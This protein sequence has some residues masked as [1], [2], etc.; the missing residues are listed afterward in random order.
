MV[1]RLGSVFEGSAALTE[2]VP[3]M[4]AQT[5]KTGREEEEEEEKG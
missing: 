2:R 3:V 1:G 5:A 4:V